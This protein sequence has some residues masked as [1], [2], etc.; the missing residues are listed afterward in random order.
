MILTTGA[1]AVYEYRDALLASDGTAANMALTMQDNLSGSLTTMKSAMEGLGIA[2][3]DYVEEPYRNVVDN[4]TKAFQN[5]TGRISSGDLATPMQNIKDAFS[6]LGDIVGPLVEETLGGLITVLGDIAEQKD[7]IIPALIGM[8]TGYLAYKAIVEGVT[9]AQGLLNTATTLFTNLNPVGVLIGAGA[10]AL[11]TL[12]AVTKMDNDSNE[13]IR[14]MQENIREI[15]GNIEQIEIKTRNAEKAF[16]DE[17]LDIESNASVA[18]ILTDQL[19][20]LADQTGRTA[21]EETK[22]KL[23][24]DKLNE[25]VPGLNLNYNEQTKTLSKT[26]EQVELLTKSYRD[27]ALYE[28]FNNQSRAYLDLYTEAVGNAARAEME[29]NLAMV[30]NESLWDDYTAEVKRQTDEFG[31]LER[32]KTDAYNALAD[33]G[34]YDIDQIQ[35]LEALTEYA[36]VIEKTGEAVKVAEDNYNEFNKQMVEAMRL[37]GLNV[38]E[39]GNLITALGDTEEALENTAEAQDELNSAL[40]QGASSTEDITDQMVQYDGVVYRVSKDVAEQFEKIEEAYDKAYDSAKESIYGQINLYEEWNSGADISSTEVLKNLN[41]YVTG[42]SQYA[43]NLDTLSTS[44]TDETGEIVATLNEGLVNYL[45]ELGPQSA[46]AIAAIAQEITNGNADYIKQL[47]ESWTN[48]YDP[49]TRIAEKN[50]EAETG[51]S[52]FVEGMIANAEEAGTTSGEKLAE[53]AV[54][55]MAEKSEEVAATAENI[56]DSMDEGLASADT[57]STA[58]GIIGDLLG[59]LVGGT[60]LAF[61]DGAAVSKSLD[62]G[63]KSANTKKTGTELV[64]DALKAVK[65]SYQQSKESG[66]YISDGITAGITSGIPAVKDAARQSA[67]AALEA[68]RAQ[69]R[70]SSPSKVAKEDAGWLPA[71]W[72]GGIESK[73]DL[74]EQAAEDVSQTALDKFVELTAPDLDVGGIVAAMQRQPDLVAQSIS[75]SGN[76][77]VSRRIS[78]DL[79]SRYSEVGIN[80]DR[81]G[82]SIARVIEG[83]TVTMDGRPVGEILTNYVD[84][85]LNGNSRLYSRGVI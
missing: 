48:Y 22:M 33:K 40:D 84:E 64:S 65:D 29:F 14:T 37:A 43:D 49:A 71:G 11:A 81:L 74:V 75:D 38:D 82:E 66:K 35:D 13:A 62:L 79:G 78:E 72:A 53:G 73:V 59:I 60:A 28:A 4:V 1:D 5:L 31:N 18:K 85:G 61:V 21:V 27:Q 16:E 23:L 56:S 2:A 57:K 54:N 50:A 44:I 17:K 32:A 52:H 70:I 34:G 80:Y 58:S 15:E 76:G 67:K 25:V 30:G 20:D 9:F 41:S 68:F 47:N 10:A 77:E 69:A 12:I 42:M 83:M 24:V 39:D 36:A 8:G 7:V 63:L 55:G 45:V 51:Y 46:S 3:Y 26:R 19:Y 6:D